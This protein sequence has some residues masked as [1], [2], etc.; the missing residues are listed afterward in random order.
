MRLLVLGGTHH[1]GRSVVE[2]ALA[3]GDEVTTLTR[4]VSGAPVAGATPRYADRTDPVALRAALGNE[5]WDVVVDTW[6]GAPRVVRDSARL[7]RDRV[8]HY[9]LISSRSVY[10]WPLPLGL[11]ESA[12]V[13]DGDPDGTDERDY[14]AA[15]R[16]AEL[17]V[18]DA[19][20]ERALLARA[21]LVLGPYED[22]G[23]LPWWLFRLARGGPV[24]APGPADRPLQYI[25]G[26]DLAGWLLQAASRGLGGAFN[27]VSAPGHTTM[28]ELLTVA[29]AVTGATAKLVWV[30][31]EA[32]AAAGIAGWTELPIWAPPTGELAA[33]HAGDVSAALAAGLRC[34]PI[35][36]TVRDTWAWLRAEGQPVP[37]GHQPPI[38]LDPQRERAVLAALV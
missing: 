6:A 16:G 13:V 21:G 33:L 29:R 19:F 31:S 26:R 14:A 12:P 15:K 28:G 34:R 18:L 27:T 17:A 2:A 32:I 24:L 22:V 1:M 8:A 30:E 9:V 5:E 23:R 36:E 7:L 20:G 35:E 11:D 4:G 37:P 25:D 38:G 10:R 3:R